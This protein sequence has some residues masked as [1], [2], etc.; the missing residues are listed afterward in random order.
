[1]SHSA[2]SKWRLSSRQNLSFP[3]NH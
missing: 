3:W 2:D 1:M